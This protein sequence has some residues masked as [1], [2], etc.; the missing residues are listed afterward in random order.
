MGG[1]GEGAPADFCFGF[2]L[3][4]ELAAFLEV[5]GSGEEVFGI[6]GPRRHRASNIRHPFPLTFVILTLHLSLLNRCAGVWSDPGHL[7]LSAAKGSPFRRQHL[8]RQRRT[9]SRTRPTARLQLFGGAGG[10]AASAC[11]LVDGRLSCSRSCYQY[12]L[13]SNDEGGESL[14]LTFFMKV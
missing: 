2:D 7:G 13:N 10:R 11:P 8:P 12:L 6:D 5:E 1:G 4:G 14:V 3:A 9:H